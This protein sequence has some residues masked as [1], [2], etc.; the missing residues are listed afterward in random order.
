MLAMMYLCSNASVNCRKKKKASEGTEKPSV[1]HLMI[2]IFY[3]Q[4]ICLLV[5]MTTIKWTGLLHKILN[6]IENYSWKL[7]G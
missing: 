2:L 6:S 1:K 4:I 5:S 7:F 3:F